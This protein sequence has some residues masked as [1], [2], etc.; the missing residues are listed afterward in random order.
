[1]PNLS[2]RTAA[3]PGQDRLVPDNMNR[4]H[5]WR[6]DDVDFEL[7]ADGETGFILATP[8]GHFEVAGQ[9]AICG[10]RM[11]VTW[12]GAITS[13]PQ[14]WLNAQRAVAHTKAVGR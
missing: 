7:W 3:P 2:I 1:M 6:A 5:Q 8:L 12:Q 14:T 10:D 9:V 4:F 13:R 11:A